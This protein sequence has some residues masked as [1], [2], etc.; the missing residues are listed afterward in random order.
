M[1]KRT[2]ALFLLG[3]TLMAPCAFAQITE[4]G[5][6]GAPVD[7]R[8]VSQPE[9]ET[10]RGLLEATWIMVIA[11]ALLCGVTWLAARN[12]S[13]DMKAS[14]AVAEMAAGAAG[15]SADAAVRSSNSANASAQ[16]ASR[17]KREMLER[18]T[19]IVAH[20]VAIAANR[21]GALVTLTSN[22]FNQIFRGY[23]ESPEK[24]RHDEILA[25]RE[26]A[27]DSAAGVLAASA[28]QK[29]DDSLAAELR[30]L[31][32]HLVRLEG[33]KE[34]LLDDISNQRRIIRENQEAMIRTQDRAERMFHK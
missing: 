14:I 21:V 6:K 22:L 8:I 12:Q 1:L 13:K 17:Q 18:E 15:R 10:N 11:N 34:E 16:L 30:Q 3:C 5:P 29:S 33:F 31:D 7:I 32:E 20:R 9:D 25:H 4:P 27:A 26:A 2:I 19:G 24:K 28:S 23:D